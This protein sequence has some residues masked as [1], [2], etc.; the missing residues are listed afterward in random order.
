MISILVDTN[1]I[2]RLL[3]E[4]DV[5]MSVSATFLFESAESGTV[6]LIIDPLIVGEC[7]DVLQGR[8][9]QLNR[10]TIVSS[11][12]PIL[13]HN[14]VNCTNLLVVLDALEMYAEQALDFADA[15]LI[16]LVRNGDYKIA[17]FDKKMQSD[18]GH[19]YHLN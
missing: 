5:E 12:I 19:F 4:D 7:C 18:D 17:T 8:V 6:S 14:G 2:L 13:V 3:L 16:A 15:Y 10:K 9:Y 11:L 1:V